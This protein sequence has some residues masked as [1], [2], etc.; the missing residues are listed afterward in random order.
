MYVF[1]CVRVNPSSKK[2]CNGGPCQACCC[3]LRCASA[4]AQRIPYP[5][6]DSNSPGLSPSASLCLFPRAHQGS[7]SPPPLSQPCGKRGA[8]LR[9]H[10]CWRLAL[11]ETY[12]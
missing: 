6:M 11:L 7:G 2:N 9:Y 8:L 1:V 4:A 12:P 10:W 5:P 3:C